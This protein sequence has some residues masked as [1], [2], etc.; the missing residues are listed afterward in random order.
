MITAQQVN[1]LRQRT[2]IGMMQCKK[3]LEEAD[4]N[5]EKAIE[6]LRKKG[7]AKAAEKSDRAMKEGI[8]VAKVAGNKASIVKMSCETDFVAKNREFTD[9]ANRVAQT[10]LKSGAEAALEEANAGIKELFVKL[11]ENM[12][13]EVRTM[14][15]E[16]IAN[17]IH[18][19]Q[20]IGALVKLSQKMEEKA[21]DI[22]MQIAAMNPLVIRPDQVSDE[23]VA[24]ERDIWR[25][26]LLAEGKPEAML[27][28]IMLGK[29]K[30]FR[31]E[32]AL[33]KQAFVKDPEKT[34]EQFLGDAQV[35]EFIRMAI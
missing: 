19:N 33:L 9:I 14:E 2:G 23:L 4:G 24:R 17:Y 1:D 34:V 7:M 25:A 21:H 26:Q 12:A 8:V 10:A 18:T 16:G 27:D 3:A 15:G 35:Q 30:K 13:I 22:A 20:K 11:G 29:E 28:K 32:S 31:E 5:E 6:I